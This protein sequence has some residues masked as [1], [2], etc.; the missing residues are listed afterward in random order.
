[1]RPHLLGNHIVTKDT[2]GVRKV[3]LSAVPLSRNLGNKVVIRDRP[4][5]SPSSLLSSCLFNPVE[6]TF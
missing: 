5:I 2:K 1:M 6:G 4:A 3:N